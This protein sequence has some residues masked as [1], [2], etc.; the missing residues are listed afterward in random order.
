[1]NDTYTKKIRKSKLTHVL[2]SGGDGGGGGG[3]GGDGGTDGNTSLKPLE[4]FER[5]DR[6][7]GKP[8]FLERYGSAVLQSV[9][10]VFVFVCAVS[11]FAVQNNLKDIQND[12]PVHRCKPN[13]MPFAGWINAPDDVDPMDY[14][15]A[16][17]QECTVN[18]F[19]QL[20]EQAMI[21]VY[22]IINTVISVLKNGLVAI[23][24]LRELFDK[25]RNQLIKIFQLIYNRIMNFL[26]PMIRMLISMKDLMKKI[27]G[28]FISIIYLL[29]GS[30]L[31]LV[32][33][34]GSIFEIIVIILIVMA[35]VIAILWALPFVGWTM[36]L[37][38]TL[39]FILIA[40]PLIMIGVFAQQV[41]HRRGS[42]VPS[43]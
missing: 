3:D 18:M 15:T 2:K 16:N 12:W 43:V 34:I 30:Y 38:A 40:I 8:Q 17:F 9:M 39:V 19:K 29:Y 31:A 37:A 14:T 22:S 13:I 4:L 5:L 32:S 24:K 28:I 7:Y 6:I 11:Y 33:L 42:S 26:I 27:Q 1:M 25:I 35:I 41:M 36:A 21:M 10:I 23:Q 20:F